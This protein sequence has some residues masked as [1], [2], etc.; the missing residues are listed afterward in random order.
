MVASGRNDT[1]GSRRLYCEAKMNEHCAYELDIYHPMYSGCP[2]WWCQGLRYRGRPTIGCQGDCE[3]EVY[4]QTPESG[5]RMALCLGERIFNGH[6]LT[7][8]R[9]DSWLI[10]KCDKR[11]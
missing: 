5:I 6:P 10:V 11:L 2:C 7:F 9:D 1:S 8:A 4:A 3:D